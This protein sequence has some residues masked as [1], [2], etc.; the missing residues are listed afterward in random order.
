[1]NILKNIGCISLLIQLA[2][3]ATAQN[4]EVS[5]PPE[6]HFPF[7]IPAYKGKLQIREIIIKGNKKTKGYMILREIQ[8]KAG[9]SIGISTLT[10]SF[11][12]ARQQVYNTALFHE[13]KVELAMLTAFQINVIVTV[14]ERWYIFPSPQFQPVD[15]SINEWLVKYNGDLTRVNYGIKFQ[16]Y[17]FSGRRDPLHLFVLNGY[18]KNL[19]FSY[20]QPYS[21]SSLTQGFGLGGGFSETRE[22]AYKTS[23]DNKILFF[24]NNNF[25]KKNVYMN[26]SLRL[27]K[28]I[29]NRH[30]FNAAYSR[31]TVSDS[32]ISKAFN[33][34]YF[35]SNR[36]TK[37]LFDISY[38]YWY[39][40]VN[41]AAYALKGVTGYLALSKRG[42]GLAGGTNLFLVEGAYNKFWAHPNNW[43][44]SLQVLGNVKLPFDQ[45]YINQK[46]IGYANANLRGLEY[47]VVDGVAFGIIKSTLKKKIFSFSIPMPFT[48][49]IIPSLPFSIFAKTYVDAGFCYNKKK[50]DTNLNNRLLYTG[51]FGIDILTL[52]DISIKIEYSFNQLGQQT[53]FFES[54]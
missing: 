45:P 31:L 39:T 41:N 29:L 26:A 7:A 30:L 44:S 14:K 24:K 27:Q 3:G 12:L 17:N 40:N 34:Y 48:S 35:N 25:V 21:N 15:R 52:Y 43:Y 1:M 53:L 47:Y 18:T 22:V 38:T 11:Q 46:A 5:M 4:I 50:F 37:G 10:E 51:G 32:V 13:V 6:A 8:F 23:A 42:F 2:V 49:S 36:S 16:H 54:R 28:G 19:A 20:S 9:D 33:P